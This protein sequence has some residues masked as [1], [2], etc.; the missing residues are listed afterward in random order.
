MIISV[1]TIKPHQTTAQLEEI[2]APETSGDLDA[3]AAIDKIDSSRRLR[4][5][6]KTHAKS[7]AHFANACSTEMTTEEVLK[8]L[9]VIA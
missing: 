6:D 4:T 5:A 2:S 3:T 9:P 1:I 8:H 7:R